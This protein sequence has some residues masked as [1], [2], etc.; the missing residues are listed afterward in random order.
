MP[1]LVRFI[2][3]VTSIGLFA[4]MSLVC[5]SVS[6][7]WLFNAPLPDW[8][9]F[10]RLL[11]GIAV[12]WGIAAAC[13]RDDHIRGDLLWPH[14]SPRLKIWVDTF[15]RLV[16]FAFVVLLIWKVFDKTLD[17]RATNQ[18]TTELRLD[19][20]PF[21][22]IAWIATLPT[23]AVAGLQLVLGIRRFQRMTGDE[24]VRKI[25]S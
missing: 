19:I 1:R 6:L 13:A 24:T 23:A 3:A 4:L 7:R 9:A 20:W 15:G 8:Y 12:F 22:A 14:L 25:D 16:I 10:S 2:E 18:E 11:L 21:Y 17:V 5:I